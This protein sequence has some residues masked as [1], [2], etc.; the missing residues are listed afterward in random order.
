MIG[1][2]S[3]EVYISIFNP[4]EENNNFEL[5]TDNFD[6]FLFT[7]L[8]AE[9]EEILDISNISPEHLQHKIIRPRIIKAYKKLESE[10]RRTDFYNM[11]SMVYI[12]VINIMLLI[13][14]SM[15]DH[16]FEISKVISELYLVWM[17]MIFN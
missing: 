7:E 2:T 9:L 3:I 4:T 12:Y 8:K 13:M 11:L 15:L 16:H 6:E 1:S 17:K 14:L 10:K 5:F